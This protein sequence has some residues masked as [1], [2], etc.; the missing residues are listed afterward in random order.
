M[1]SSRLHFLLTAL[2][3]IRRTFAVR[4]VS[5]VHFLTVYLVNFL[6]AEGE[7]PFTLLLST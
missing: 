4:V 5:A 1:N 6:A 3:L 2:T 7:M